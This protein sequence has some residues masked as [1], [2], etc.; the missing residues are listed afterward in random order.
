M[1]PWTHLLMI[2]FSIWA[3]SDLTLTMRYV[4]LYTTQALFFFSPYQALSPV[5][6][7]AVQIS[8]LVSATFSAN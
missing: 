2:F 8:V 1:M 6:L 7:N 3:Q 5:I 4:K